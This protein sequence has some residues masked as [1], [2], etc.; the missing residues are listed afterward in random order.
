MLWI[1][2]FT[3]CC[4]IK[5]SCIWLICFWV[6]LIIMWVY[7]KCSQMVAINDPTCW[8]FCVGITVSQRCWLLV[9]LLEFR[10][11]KVSWIRNH[12]LNVIF[13]L[14]FSLL[15]LTVLFF[16][17]LKCF[18]VFGVIFL[19]DWFSFFLVFFCFWCCFWLR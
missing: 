15:C 10:I 3:P 7:I 17:L 14:I 9:K 12:R 8:L 18:L 6:I 2:A 16:E 1:I 19:D 5:S 4:E 13:Y 11:C